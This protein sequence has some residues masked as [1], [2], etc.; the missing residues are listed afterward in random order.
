MIV[1]ISRSNPRIGGSNA[2]YKAKKVNLTTLFI[3]YQCAPELEVSFLKNSWN[4]LRARIVDSSLQW[5]SSTREM[6]H[7]FRQNA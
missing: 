4:A 5:F 6:C 3:Y 1:F 2:S 7:L